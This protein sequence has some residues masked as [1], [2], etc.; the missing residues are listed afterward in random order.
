MNIVTQLFFLLV[1]NSFGK[2]NF[3][4]NLS[5]VTVILKKI[6]NIFK[7]IFAALKPILQKYFQ[8][9]FETKQDTNIDG[10]AFQDSKDNFESD[11]NDIQ[12]QV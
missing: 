3:H 11:H 7:S 12:H 1:Q 2:N 5:R 6:Q 10:L 9:C 8:N 4:F